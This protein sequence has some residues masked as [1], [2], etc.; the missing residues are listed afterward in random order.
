MEGRRQWRATLPQK[1]ADFVRLAQIMTLFLI[2]VEPERG[3]YIF[4]D[5][6]DN[7][8]TVNIGRMELMQ[9]KQSTVAV[10]QVTKTI[11]FIHSTSCCEF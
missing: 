9:E 7:Q 11:A 1:Y 2:H 4:T 10:F 8:Y 3:L 5:P 6:L